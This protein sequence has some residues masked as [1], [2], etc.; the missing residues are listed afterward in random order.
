MSIAKRI[1]AA[2]FMPFQNRLNLLSIQRN[3]TFRHLYAAQI[4]SLVGTGLATVALGLL[5]WKLAG[6][7]A[8]PVL[9]T[10]MAIKMTSYVTLALSPRHWRRGC[11]GGP[12]S[13]H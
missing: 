8:G 2:I 7:N 6:A 4:I 11:H 13:S 5:A 9:G 12:F 1:I 10:V 3:R